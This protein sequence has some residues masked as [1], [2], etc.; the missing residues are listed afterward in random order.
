MRLYKLYIIITSK[1]VIIRDIVW[2]PRDS[3]TLM[4]TLAKESVLLPAF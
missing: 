3:L 1:V 2:T 4:L